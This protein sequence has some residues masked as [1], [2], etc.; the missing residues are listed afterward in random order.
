MNTDSLVI[1]SA[2]KNLGV[3]HNGTKAELNTKTQRHNGITDLIFDML[4]LIFDMSAFRLAP[5]CLGG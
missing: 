4:D 2:A 3:Y 1:L 5:W